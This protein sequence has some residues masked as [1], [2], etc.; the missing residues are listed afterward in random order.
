MIRN[1]LKIALRNL[2][3]DTFYSLINVLGLTIGVTCGMLLLLYVTDE[4]SYDRYHTKAD[5]IY[6]V[7]SKIREPDKSFGWNTTQPPL[8]ETLK[9][10]LPLH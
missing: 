4:L 10:G 7:V 9:A 8:V 3:K 6:R 5:Q 1:Y 2:Q